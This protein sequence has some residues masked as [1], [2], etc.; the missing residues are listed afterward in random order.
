MSA[1]DDTMD[2]TAQE[3]FSV[4]YYN[5]PSLPRLKILFFW[6]ILIEW[7]LC[8]YENHTPI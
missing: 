2:F 7:K 4:E 8:T 1:R 6:V 5:A 3:Q